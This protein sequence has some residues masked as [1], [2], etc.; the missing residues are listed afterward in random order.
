MS[1]VAVAAA[2]A[3]P[4]VTT[5]ALALAGVWP[6]DQQV[7]LVEGDPGGGDLAA[8]FGLAAQPGLVSLAA[9]ARREV[10]RE[11][12]SV[13]VAEHAQALPGGL[14]VLVGPPGTEQAAAA[15]GMLAPAVVAGLDGLDGVDVVADLGRLDPG[16][17]ALG[18]ARAASLLVLVVR[19]RLA[20]LQHLAHRAAALRPECRALGLVVVGTGPYPAEEIAAALGVEVLATLPADSA[21]P[22]CSAVE[23]RASARCAGPR[24]SAQPAAWRR[25]SSAG[26]LARRR[27]RQR[28]R[29]PAPS[30]HLLPSRLPEPSRPHRWR[31]HP[32]PRQRGRCDDER[33]LGRRRGRHVDR[34]E[35]WRRP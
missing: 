2:K 21:P 22:A 25:R 11:V 31:H 26:W 17:P 24:W 34:E 12:D 14:G 28:H 7:L 8:H 33:R 19:P 20:E 3:A 13:L 15:L 29:W 10:D 4:G 6:A 27:Q 30:R 5:S 32:S 1:L 18:L 16:S 9:A 23:R 35:R